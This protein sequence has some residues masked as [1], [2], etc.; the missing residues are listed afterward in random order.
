M[1]PGV[2]GT[3]LHG[4]FSHAFQG[5]TLLRLAARNA[6]EKAPSAFWAYITD[7]VGCRSSAHGTSG[8]MGFG[9]MQSPVGVPPE[10]AEG[11]QDRRSWIDLSDAPMLR[12]RKAKKLANLHRVGFALPA[13]PLTRKQLT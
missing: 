1:L 5:L 8:W 3:I 9:V 10:G 13:P 7:D 2:E 11:L 12:L 6:V 4:A